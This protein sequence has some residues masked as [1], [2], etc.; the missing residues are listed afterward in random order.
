MELSDK[1]E[2]WLSF[3]SE[4]PWAGHSRLRRLLGLCGTFPCQDCSRTRPSVLQTRLGRSCL[5][6]KAIFMAC[7][8]SR[9]AL[10]KP[11]AVMLAEK[12]RSQWKR[13][14]SRPPLCGPLS[15]SGLVSQ[16]LADSL[17]LLK[18]STQVTCHFIKC[19]LIRA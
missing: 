15:L 7:L 13:L 18:S 4:R 12:P 3:R 11:L 2:I 1:W 19:G 9:L 17:V 14:A 6:Q 8:L 10:M 5:S 16:N